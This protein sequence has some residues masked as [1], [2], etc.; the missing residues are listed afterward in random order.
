MTRLMP[1]W[2]SVQRSYRSA[3]SGARSTTRWMPLG[4]REVRYDPN[5]GQVRHR[6]WLGTVTMRAM[7]VRFRWSLAS[8]SA[9]AFPETNDA[10]DKRPRGR[11]VWTRQH[12]GGLQ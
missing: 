2:S 12:P 1:I 7:H 11:A 3:N 10:E 9:Q 4:D 5:V 6:R 8:S